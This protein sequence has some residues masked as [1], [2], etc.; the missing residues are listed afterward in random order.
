MISRVDT[1]TS[2]TK[3]VLNEILFKQISKSLDSND[4]LIKKIFLKT[5][6]K[7]IYFVLKNDFFLNFLNVSR[8]NFRLFNL[9][10]K[11]LIF[12]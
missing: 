1:T 2:L 11:M 4:S 8:L 3:E 12:F 10:F 5:K 9:K 7:S 6:I